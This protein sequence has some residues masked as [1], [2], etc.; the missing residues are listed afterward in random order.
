[1]T[2]GHSVGEVAAAEAAGVLSLSDAVNV[3]YHRSRHQELTENSGGMAVIFGP[4]DTATGLVAEFRISRSQR[5]TRIN[6]S[7]LQDPPKRWICWPSSRQ[8]TS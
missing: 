5:I 6:A 4:H 8:R 1:M 2:M 7:P 3:I